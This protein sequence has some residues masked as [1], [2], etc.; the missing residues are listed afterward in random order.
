MQIVRMKVAPDTVA[1]ARKRRL[2][3]PELKRQLQVLALEDRRSISSTARLIIKAYFNDRA[4]A[5]K[6]GPDTSPS[7]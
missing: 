4:K 7:G 3:G 5:K 6:S 2:E 1:Y